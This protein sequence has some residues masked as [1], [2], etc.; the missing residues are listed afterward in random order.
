MVTVVG[1]QFAAGGAVLAGGRRRH[2]VERASLEA[3]RGR[4]QGTNRTDLDD[5]AREVGVVGILLVGA[6]LLQCAALDQSDERVARDLLGEPGAAG[7]E[8]AALA[9]QQDLRRDTHRL[10]ERALD[11]LVAALRPAVGHGLILQ[12]AL[13][14]LVAD[15]AVQRVV[16]EQELDHAVLGLLRHRRGDLGVDLHAL[17]H[18]HGAGGLRLRE[19]TAVAGVGDVNHALAA[20]ADGVEQRVVAEARDR[21]ADHLGGP[22]DQRALGNADLLAVDGQRDEIRLGRQLSGLGRLGVDGHRASP[23]TANRA[24]FS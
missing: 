4:G 1:A 5:V 18:R 17:G 3:V 15:R 19:P 10:G 23:S 2:E 9:V 16:D 21:G 20:G 7:A 8:D 14:A 11:A 24:L 13:A 22:D 6:D 12:G